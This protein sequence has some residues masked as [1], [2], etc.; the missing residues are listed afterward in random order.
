VL[1]LGAEHQGGGEEILGTKREPRVREEGSS[2][3]ELVRNEGSRDGKPAQAQR[4]P[5]GAPRKQPGWGGVEVR[6]RGV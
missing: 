4:R 6:R 3:A 5:A 2:L 1:G